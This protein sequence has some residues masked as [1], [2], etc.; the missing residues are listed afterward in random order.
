[1]DLMRIVLP[2]MEDGSTILFDD[3]DALHDLQMPFVK[4]AVQ[5]SLSLGF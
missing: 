4:D 5:H 3:Q 1:L 2:R